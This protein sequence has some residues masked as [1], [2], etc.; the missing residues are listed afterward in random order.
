[1]PPDESGRGTGAEQ[2]DGY[3]SA[4]FDFFEHMGFDSDSLRE[5]R[6]FYVPMFDG[7]RDVLDVA[8][9]RGE[10]LEALGR[11]FGVDIEEAMVRAARQAGLDVD[12]GDALR[13][14]AEH[15]ESFDGIFSAH[16]IEHLSYERAADLFAKTY[17][18][19]RPGGVMV[20]ATPNAASLPTLQRHFWWDATHV[21]MYDPALLTFMAKQAGFESVEEGVNPRN[22]PGCPVDVEHLAL[23]PIMPIEAPGQAQHQF[24]LLDERTQV[25]AHHVNMIASSLRGLVRAL[26]TP[27]EIYVQGIKPRSDGGA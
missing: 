24:R 1:M 12:L 13:Y 4:E 16:F 26:Y 17:A 23:P 8:C 27:S 10:F 19:L 22:D 5:S 2:V 21:R 20:L 14:L 9:G 7:C 18:A 6:A 15:E 25:L 3:R 11:G